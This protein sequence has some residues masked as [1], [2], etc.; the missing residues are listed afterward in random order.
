MSLD[1]PEPD[2]ASGTVR[3]SAPTKQDQPAVA[4][5][6]SWS[7]TDSDVSGDISR[8]DAG[9]AITRVEVNSR[10]PAG[11]THQLVRKIPLGEILALGRAHLAAL[12]VPADVR[13]AP[14]P[15]PPGRVLMTPELLREV[16]QAYIEE[17]G[18]GKDR[19]VFQRLE[20][21]FQRPKGTLRTWIAKARDEGW[22]GPA[23]QGRGGAEPGPRLSEW[24]L[25]ELKHKNPGLISH[26]RVEK[27]GSVTDLSDPESE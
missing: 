1:Q 19:A 11:I 16:A 2:P 13:P 5:R 10:L 18:P 6:F 8:G 25:N 7:G 14:T 26:V 22:L 17:S 3:F 21:R 24:Q 15:L 4:L 12:E 9:L 23:V 27:D 20:A